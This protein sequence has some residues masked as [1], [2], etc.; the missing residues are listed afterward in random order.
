MDPK[1]VTAVAAI[2]ISRSSPR[3]KFCGYEK[4]YDSGVCGWLTSRL[5]MPYFQKW[6]KWGQVHISRQDRTRLSCLADLCMDHPSSLALIPETKRPA[7][8]CRPFCEYCDAKNR[9][10]GFCSTR[11]SAIRLQRRL[12]GRRRR[13]AHEY[14]DS[15][16]PCAALGGPI[17]RD[18][19]VRAT[20]I[21]GDAI[22]FNTVPHDVLAR[23]GGT[24]Y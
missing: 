4:V 13:L 19:F 10:A 24:L 23:A 7:R 11:A 14:I 22:P 12:L 5:P 1:H 9:Y 16:I 2:Y 20:P 21:N 17:V 15:S 3:R 18:R 6:Q 8:L